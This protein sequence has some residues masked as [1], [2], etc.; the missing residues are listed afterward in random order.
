LCRSVSV[1]WSR[2]KVAN[3]PIKSLLDHVRVDEQYTNYEAFFYYMI[4]V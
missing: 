1:C 3:L 4:Y 2:E